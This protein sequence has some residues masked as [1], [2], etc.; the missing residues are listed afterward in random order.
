MKFEKVERSTTL[1]IIIK[2]IKD[3]IRSG[4]IQSG[5]KLPSERELS[6]IMGVSR[7]SVR[8]AIKALTFSGYL[9]VIQGKGAYVSESALKYDGISNLLS[10][11]SDF[12]ISS[13][14]EARIMLE[15]E[16]ARLAALRANENDIEEIE[17]C[18]YGMRNS[19][20][21]RLFVIKDLD[22]HMT[23]AEATHNKFMSTLMKIIG[24]LLHKETHEITRYSIPIRD[25][26]INVSDELCKAIKNKDAKTAKQLMIDHLVVVEKSMN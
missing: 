3:Q 2:Q 18:L 19:D 13:L 8:E 10:K 25:K 11:I 1:E 23:I 15:G 4:E 12:S 20:S 9:D 21:I 5:D 14:I 22:F 17:N 6:E 7:T 16:F 26:I 24:D